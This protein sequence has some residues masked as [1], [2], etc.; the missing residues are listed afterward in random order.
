[1]TSRFLA[2]SIMKYVPDLVRLGKISKMQR[3]DEKRAMRGE[4]N[5]CT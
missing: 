2:F 1:M 3:Q 5:I 4:A